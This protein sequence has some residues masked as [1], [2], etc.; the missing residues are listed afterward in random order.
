[1]STVNANVLFNSVSEKFIL[2]GINE[3]QTF[4]VPE[5]PRRLVD[6][7]QEVISKKLK[8]ISGFGERHWLVDFLN[9]S[10]LMY[11]DVLP[12]IKG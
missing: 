2:E 5:T 10:T 9:N 4:N 12:Q 3:A 8:N 7:F 11:K 6:H 1:M